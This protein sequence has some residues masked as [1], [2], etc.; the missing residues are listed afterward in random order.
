MEIG[1]TAGDFILFFKSFSVRG[2]GFGPPVCSRVRDRGRTGGL[3]VGGV[4]DRP[5]AP[6]Q[7]EVPPLRLPHLWGGG[8]GAPTR[9]ECAVAA[10]GPHCWGGVRTT[11]TRRPRRPPPLLCCSSGPR[12]CT[13]TPSWV[14]RVPTSYE[15]RTIPHHLPTY[16][17][18]V[19]ARCACL[20]PST[21]GPEQFS[22]SA[23]VR[24]ESYLGGPRKP[25][26]A[27]SGSALAV[28]ALFGARATTTQPRSWGGG[29]SSQEI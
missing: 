22:P 19:D 3:G 12:G 8:H 28:V 21:F 10:V 13:G 25:P 9:T 1:M 2:N 18:I 16:L 26:P 14:P 23:R 4:V 5:A 29:P 6:P 15:T 20:S 11:P 24:P 7:A 27:P 17:E